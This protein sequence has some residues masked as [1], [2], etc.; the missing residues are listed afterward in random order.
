MKRTD[1]GF[2]ITDEEVKKASKLLGYVGLAMLTTR[3]FR[4]LLWPATGDK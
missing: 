1:E 4:L 2:L 3:L